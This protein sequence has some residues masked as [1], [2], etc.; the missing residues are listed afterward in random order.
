MELVPYY[1]GA[2]LSGSIPFGWLV[3]R[4]R[5]VDIREA[6]SGNI[7]A[8]NVGRVLGRKYAFLVFALDFFKGLIPTWL[9]VRHA[10]NGWDVIGIAILAVMG[11]VFPIWLRFKGGKGIATG[12]GALTALI[13]VAVLVGITLWIVLYY[14]T[15]YVS[16]ASLA[17]A[18]ALPITVAIH[19][20]TAPLFSL[21]LFAAGLAI[22]T[23][24]SNIVGLIKGTEHRF[25]KPS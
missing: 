14:T 25:T 7:G 21:A 12:A 18:I 5:G 15:R 9:A 3:A 16:I 22:F 23:H 4:A 8:T 1:I 24:R 20:F 13:P 6:G 19:H 17:G 11:H 10:G 2:Y